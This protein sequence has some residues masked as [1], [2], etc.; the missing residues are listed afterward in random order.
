[1][2]EMFIDKCLAKYRELFRQET[3]NKDPEEEALN[4]RRRRDEFE[5]FFFI[6]MN[7]TI[8]TGEYLEDDYISKIESFENELITED[9]LD[10]EH[11]VFSLHVRLCLSDFRG[12]V[13]NIQN[14]V[15]LRNED[16]L[17]SFI[18]KE[19][20]K[21]DRKS[22]YQYFE[23]W[24]I[25]SLQLLY[26][27]HTLIS[28]SECKEA[29]IKSFYQIKSKMK[30]LA[31]QDL[32]EVFAKLKSKCSFLL[33]KTLVYNKRQVLHYA[34]D[35]TIRSVSDITE[36]DRYN[37]DFVSRFNDM[38]QERFGQEEVSKFKS[39][40][41]DGKYS[42]I[43]FIV[44]AYY[45]RISD[46][47]DVERLKTLCG[48]FEEYYNQQINDNLCGYDQYALRSI[49]NYLC[50][51]RFSHALGQKHYK[52]ENLKEDISEIERIQE[53][54]G[55]RNYHPYK[56]ALKFLSNLLVGDSLENQKDK[57][58]NTE[59]FNEI[60]EK[61]KST[62]E[63]CIK[64]RF[65]PFLLPKKDCCTKEN[66]FIA[67]TFSRPISPGKLRESEREFRDLRQYLDTSKRLEKR[68]RE[69]KAIASRLDSFR[70]ESFEY[71]GVFITVITFLFGSTQ[72][73]GNK[74]AQLPSVITNIAS[75]GIVLGMFMAM[76]YIILYCRRRRILFLLGLILLCF[77]IL[78]YFHSCT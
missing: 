28:N 46:S 14:K 48:K 1:M 75:L 52:V 17:V 3:E 77:L 23:A 5:R 4:I 61:Y 13:F 8:F 11:N 10:I 69:I 40:F 31:N 44:L 51:C 70:K 6:E 22:D 9:N 19:F 20:A 16:L 34:V 50:N 72:L 36:K 64:K 45:Y 49:R 35:Y 24:R 53:E 62:Y 47:N 43:G 29:L 57:E 18:S 55:L 59:L 58:A 78:V 2:E 65:S 37:E 68:E 66:L 74:E 73:F 42:C 60:F 33:H 39:D 15:K 56:K 26:F 67:S 25:I 7:N 21:I 41:K 71:L 38:F 32:L 27:D 30:G 63:L 12:M 76:L 54:D